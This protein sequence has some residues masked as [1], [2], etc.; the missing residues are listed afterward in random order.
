MRRQRPDPSVTRIDGPW[1][2]LEVHANGI[3]FQVV[4]ADPDV[5]APDRWVVRMALPLSRLVAGGAKPGDAL[6]FNA[7]RATHMVQALAWSPTYGEFRA[8]ERL[9]EIRL[10]PARAF[11]KAAFLRRL[12]KLH[13]RLPTQLESAGDLVRRMRDGDRY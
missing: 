2:H 1:R 10:A 3:R 7:L 6:Y 5:S 13:A 11:D 12:R 8:P 4:E 9:G